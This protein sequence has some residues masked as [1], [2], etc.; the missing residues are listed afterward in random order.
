[1]KNTGGLFSIILKTKSINK[2]EKFC[3]SLKHFL[4]A[5]SWGGHESLI[6]PICA[7]YKSQNYKHDLPINLI[8]IYIGLEDSKLLI[9]DIEQALKKI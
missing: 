9:S 8:R 5:C 4:I 6:F 3:D 1:M 2:I 7:L